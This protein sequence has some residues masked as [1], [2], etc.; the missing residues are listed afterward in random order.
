MAESSAHEA[1]IADLR[2]RLAANEA[3]QDELW[4]HFA[5]LRA[6]SLAAGEIRGD[7]TRSDRRMQELAEQ[8]R[9]FGEDIER[10][11]QEFDSRQA[12]RAQRLA[13]A[14]T[15]AAEAEAAYADLRAQ[16][17]D[18]LQANP[19]YRDAAARY[20]YTRQ[21]LEALTTRLT[22][23]RAECEAKRPAYENDILFMHLLK[24]GYARHDYAHR[25][26]ARR[27]D[28]WI[29]E[30][31]DFDTAYADY[32][33]LVDMPA[34]LT[35]NIERLETR[36]QDH[37][38]ALAHYWQQLARAGELKQRRDTARQAHEQ[39]ER[40]AESIAREAAQDQALIAARP[41]FDAHDDQY[42][43]DMRQ[44]YRRSFAN[45]PLAAL[46]TL[47]AQTATE[48]DAR[49]ID[50]LA[51]LQAEHEDLSQRLASLVPDEADNEAGD[52]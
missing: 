1:R 11:V 29:A 2:T 40:L 16:L 25:G 43:R 42:A 7:L 9:V 17:E 36:L 30:L 8:R 49:A 32:S 14:R 18:E 41:A 12:T 24:R 39:A 46:R 5:E 27:I 38:R 34:W 26:W 13:T 20:E 37:E 47:A 35:E 23:A 4:Q 19:D 28:D 15:Q 44:L 50:D 45:Q 21:T 33:L 31:V 6:R 48:L 51:R 52:D 3:R 22:D 10:A